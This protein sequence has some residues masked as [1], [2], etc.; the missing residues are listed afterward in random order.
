[1]SA[2]PM[3]VTVKPAV[4]PNRLLGAERINS[5]LN[6]SVLLF[7]PLVYRQEYDAGRYV[8]CQTDARN[9]STSVVIP[10]GPMV[11]FA[12]AHRITN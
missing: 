6:T 5:F 12:D 2:P 1:M 10:P 3:P 9:L 7:R 4:E 11:L 8:S